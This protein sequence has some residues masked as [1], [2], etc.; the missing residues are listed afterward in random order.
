MP[1]AHVYRLSW[2]RVEPKCDY[3]STLSSSCLKDVKGGCQRELLPVT[4]LSLLTLYLVSMR[5]SKPF[6]TIPKLPLIA[7]GLGK[8]EMLN[9]RLIIPQ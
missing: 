5:T 3:R 8:F 2:Y 9:L 1:E 7:S 6:L 4:R